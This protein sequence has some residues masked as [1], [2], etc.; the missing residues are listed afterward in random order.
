MFTTQ[1]EAWPLMS[2]GRPRTHTWRKQNEQDTQPCV[3]VSPS[4]TYALSQGAAGLCHGLLTFVPE[5]I[6][7]T[8][9]HLLNEPHGPSADSQERCEQMEDGA[10]GAT[11]RGPGSEAQIPCAL[12]WPWLEAF[13]G[14]VPPIPGV[15]AHSDSSGEVCV[16]AGHRCQPGGGL[17]SGGLS[18]SWARVVSPERLLLKEKALGP[19]GRPP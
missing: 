18:T 1:G 10:G 5:D 4:C 17:L 16:G 13:G 8:C 15:R 7:P 9:V 19:S 3:P 12:V 14:V 6:F 11:Y 2:A